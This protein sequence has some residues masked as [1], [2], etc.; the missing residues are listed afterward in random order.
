MKTTQASLY[1][2]RDGAGAMRTITATEMLDILYG[3]AP[4]P[5]PET[6]ETLD[7]EQEEDE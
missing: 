1:Y 7:V 3:R 2:G 5:E 4:L 6:D